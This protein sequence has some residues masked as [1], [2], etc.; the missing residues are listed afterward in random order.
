MKLLLPDASLRS[1][2]AV[3]NKSDMRDENVLSAGLLQH[4]A[5]G[6]LSMFTVPRGQ[7]IPRL[8]G[9]GI[10]AP[11]SAHQTTYT[12]L[13]TN[14]TQAGQTGSGIGDISV[15]SIGVTIEN[16]YYSGA[17]IATNQGLNA[18]G[19]GSQEVSEILGKCFFQF[20]VAG[21]L[22]VQGPAFLFPAHGAVFG[23]AA[24]ATTAAATS[25]VVGS[26]N[27]GW[28]GAGR[29]LKLPILVART[30]VLEGR[31]GV[32][33]GDSLVFSVTTGVG[34]PVL[35]WAN[36]QAAVKGDAR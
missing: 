4:G 24:V 35:V 7:P 21:K 12:E 15:R 8:A 30:D 13:T 17:A 14:L 23:G 1:P 36:L 2:T 25:A 9:A 31:F 29:R 19:A 20:L 28:P 11:T 10:T 18:Y 22:Q 33:G 32:A 6:T 26:Q 27:N 16:G 5:N 3:P 34:Q